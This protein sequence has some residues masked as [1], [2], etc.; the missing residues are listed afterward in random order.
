MLQFLAPNEAKP[1]KWGK[2]GDFSGFCFTPA[3]N[4]DVS[5]PHY[6]TAEMADLQHCQHRKQIQF[7]F[8]LYLKLI[9]EFTKIQRNPL[10][11]N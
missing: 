11:F 10:S 9:K 3:T 7:Q 2:T 5:W 8:Q 6:F 4:N 1:L